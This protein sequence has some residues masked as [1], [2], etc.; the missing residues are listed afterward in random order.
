MANG[1]LTFDQYIGGPDQVII[2]QAFP[3]TQRSV[4]YNFDRDIT[5]WTFS[6]D[7]Q[8]IVVDQISFNRYTGAPN[9]ANSIVIGSFAKVDIAPGPNAPEII[10]AATGTVK[11]TFPAQMYT[12]P[13]IPDARKNVPIVVFGFTWNIA[14]TPTQILSNR[15]A[16]I[17]CYEPDVAIGDPTL[18]A[19]Y[20]PMVVA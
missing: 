12:G 3:S 14:S 19:G 10:N 15:W 20:I 17:Q 8:T 4:V 11:V 13:I 1:V 7:Y 6:A 16:F 9:F 2:E 5:G 18:A